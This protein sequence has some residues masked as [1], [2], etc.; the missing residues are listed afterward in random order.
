MEDFEKML[1]EI[2]KPEVKLLKHQDLMADKVVRTKN[3]NVLSLWWLLVPLYVIA[4]LTMKTFFMKTSFKHEIGLFKTTNPV[5]SFM[6]F[7]MLPAL[8]III[9]SFFSARRTLIGKA[10]IILSCIVLFIYILNCYV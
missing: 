2:S 9:T 7:L 5:L 4:T 1:T 8:I 10:L 6:L 3:R